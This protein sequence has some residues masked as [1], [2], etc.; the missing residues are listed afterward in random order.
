MEEYDVG[1][2]CMMNYFIA[3]HFRKY[4]QNDE[5]KE[6]KMDSVCNMHEKKN[7]YRNLLKE[8]EG[9]RPLG[10]S[11]RRW[12]DN[13]MLDLQEIGWAVTESIHLDQDGIRSCLL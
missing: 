6:S 9:K 2:N 11:K 4:N 13:I 5:V 12:K 1:E 8:T 10:R 3:M 7:A